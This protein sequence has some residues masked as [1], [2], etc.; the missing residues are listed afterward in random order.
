MRFHLALITNDLR[1]RL[2]FLEKFRKVPGNF[3][4]WNHGT[5]IQRHNHHT[6]RDLKL[7]RQKR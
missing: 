5:T 2:T 3:E 7:F 1:E 4:L 6:I